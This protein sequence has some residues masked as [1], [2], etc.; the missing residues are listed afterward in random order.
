MKKWCEYSKS[1]K[2]MVLVI[3]TLL[4]AV[5]LSHSRVSDGIE[6]GMDYFYPEWRK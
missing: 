2:R 6:K 5:I 4:L 3:G 1:E